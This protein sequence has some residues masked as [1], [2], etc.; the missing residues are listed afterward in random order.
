M[1]E[2]K[3]NRSIVSGR[4][5]KGPEY[6]QTGTGA[7][8]V[9]FTIEVPRE[10]NSSITDYI[11]CVVWDGLVGAVEKLKIGDWVLVS[12]KLTT[13]SVEKNGNKK[14]YTEIRVESLE[15]GDI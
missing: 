9:N 5:V 13:H 7:K 14:R 12:G 6:G 3:I 15:T 4:I 8:V 2:E 1:G 11:D 10:F